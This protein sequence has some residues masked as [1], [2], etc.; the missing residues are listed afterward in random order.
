MKS[1]GNTLKDA[2]EI[3]NLTLRQVEEATDISNA[4]LS[5]LENDKIKKPSANVLYKLATIYNVELNTLLMASGIIEKGTPEKSKLLN[6]IALSSEKLT[7]EE[8]QELLE[9]LKYLRHKRNG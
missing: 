7:Y 2:R 1:L 4:Y 3:N 9:Y 6:S 8:E 5:Q